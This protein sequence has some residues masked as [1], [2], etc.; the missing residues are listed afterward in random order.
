M[1]PYTLTTREGESIS[2][3]TSTRTVFDENGVDLET[4]LANQ[5]Q[6]ADNMLKEYAKKTEVTQ[7]LAGKQDA[8]TP[9]ADL[10]I[11]ADNIIGLTEKG[12]MRVFIDMFNARCVAT[13]S[14]NPNTIKRLTF[15]K[16][17]PEN[18]PDA[19]HPF[20]LNKLWLTY[21]EAIEPMRV[22]DVATGD[23]TNST[24]QYVKARTLF[25]ISVNGTLRGICQNMHKLETVRFVDYYIINN[26]NNPDE[27]LIRITSTR[28]MFERCENLRE[29]MGI[30]QLPSGDDMGVHFYNAFSNCISLETI[31]L[32][33][34]QLD[35]RLNY[36]KS[37][38]LECFAYMIEHA[39]N[40]KS[41]TITVH[42]DV[43]AKLTGDATNEAAGALTEEEA[44]AWQQVLAD[45]VAKNISFATA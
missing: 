40:T 14:S 1:K 8:L 41:I 26:G 34:I 15:G 21:E 33:S 28:G 27:S 38:K 22:P 37:L 20:Y 24:F 25:P 39:A 13:S 35:T 43:Y 42:A 16:Y 10:Q 45:A 3:M 4:R 11:T 18:A 30:L 29:I 32:H 23:Q 36:C 44:A 7:A 6:A 9:T 17:D 19:Q 12:K 5:K 31:W 2:P